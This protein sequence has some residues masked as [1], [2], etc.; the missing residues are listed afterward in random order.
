MKNKKS[1]KIYCY[2]LTMY[3]K[4]IKEYNIK[5]SD[6]IILKEKLI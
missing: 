4:L 2:S 1:T 5:E 3:Y 6:I